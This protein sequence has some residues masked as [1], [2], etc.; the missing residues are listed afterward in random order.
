MTAVLQTGAINWWRDGKCDTLV[1]LGK[2]EKKLMTEK[3]GR[4][5]ATLLGRLRCARVSIG[6][7]DF[8]GLTAVGHVFH[9]PPL[10]DS[11]A[12]HVGT[13]R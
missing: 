5:E 4:L 10:A 3:L 7:D 13:Q 9:C 8:V 11:H 1:R 6:G 12:V 2:K